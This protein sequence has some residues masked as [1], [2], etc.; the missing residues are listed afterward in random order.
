MMV[1]LETS[2]LVQLKRQLRPGLSQGENPQMYGCT[3]MAWSYV[4]VFSNVGIE[5]AKNKMYFRT[6]SGRFWSRYLKV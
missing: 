3:G 5:V 6:R 4:N 1:L 2:C